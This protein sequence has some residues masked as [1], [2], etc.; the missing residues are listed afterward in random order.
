MPS[1][2]F[3]ERGKIDFVERLR[4]Q[5][6]DSNWLF[7]NIATL[8]NLSDNC[9]SNWA[10]LIAPLSISQGLDYIPQNDIFFPVASDWIW[11]PLGS[12]GF[13]IIAGKI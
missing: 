8:F 5:V 1:Y 9:R 4:F 7:A 3:E 6:M 13:D 10:T 2:F 11:N 12:K